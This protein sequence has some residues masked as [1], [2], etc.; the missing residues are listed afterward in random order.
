MKTDVFESLHYKI[1]KNRILR[2]LSL[3]SFYDSSSQKE[4]QLLQLTHKY[5]GTYPTWMFMDCMRK[6]ISTV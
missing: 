2:I 1:I 6:Q 4:N 3:Y 5:V